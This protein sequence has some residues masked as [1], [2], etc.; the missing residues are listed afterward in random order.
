MTQ[1]PQRI[2]NEI[3][4]EQDLATN[5]AEKW[6]RMKEGEVERELE[7]QARKI[8]KTQPNKVVVAYQEVLP[9]L[10]EHNAIQAYISDHNRVGLMQVLV[11][12]LNPKEAV[13]LMT[14]E[15]RLQPENQER[16]R[17]LL[18]QLPKVP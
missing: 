13:M 2:W 10:A 5:W 17:E 7:K 9:L 6:F 12:V 15:H 8:L 1:V 14:M 16:L 3:A 4:K 18:E 11:E